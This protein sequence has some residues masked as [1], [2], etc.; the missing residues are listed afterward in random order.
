ML[1]AA[2]AGALA[3]YWVAK[4]AGKNAAAV[5]AA[6]N[7]TSRQNVIYQ[8]TGEPGLSIADWFG[9]IFKSDAERKV[10]A[11]LATTPILATKTPLISA[12]S[13]VVVS[14]TLQSGADR[15]LIR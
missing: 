8:A 1:V 10:D 15:A 2:G 3:L 7:P 6:V 14:G 9:G 5:A 12:T 13:P 11:M 4:Q